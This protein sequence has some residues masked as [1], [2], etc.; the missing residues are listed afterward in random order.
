MGWRKKIGSSERKLR[1]KYGA[2]LADRKLGFVIRK[3]FLLVSIRDFMSVVFPAPAGPITSII[4]GLP[5]MDSISFFSNL[6]L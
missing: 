6:Y 2:F 4:N 5:F 3:I 1:I